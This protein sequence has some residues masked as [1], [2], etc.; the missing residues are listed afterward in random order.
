MAISHLAWLYSIQCVN[1]PGS[2]RCTCPEGFIL[3]ANGRACEDI[4]EC[5]DPKLSP[6]RGKHLQCQR[7]KWVSL[8]LR[9]NIFCSVLGENNYCFNTRGG[10]KCTDVKC[11]PDYEPERNRKH[12]CRLTDEARRCPSTSDLE[13]I[14]RPV[15]LSYNF[16]TLGKELHWVR[17]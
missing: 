2:Y 16:L 13:C 4:N 10:Y 7:K 5:A 11:P 15:S 1:E 3:S 12:R 9:I 17:G 8:L 6:C 14:R